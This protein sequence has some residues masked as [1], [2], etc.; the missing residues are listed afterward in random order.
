MEQH[1]PQRTEKDVDR[2]LRSKSRKSQRSHRQCPTCGALLGKQAAYCIMCGYDFAKKEAPVEKDGHIRRM[3]KVKMWKPRK[4]SPA[5]ANLAALLFP[6]KG[7]GPLLMGALLALITPV[8]YFFLKWFAT[9]L[10]S[11][12]EKLLLFVATP[13]LL[14]FAACTALLILVC[15]VLIDQRLDS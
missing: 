13:E 6:L 10:H 4:F 3:G 7:I 9:P 2:R 1:K 14:A 5:K 11:P 12:G 15:F 8:Y